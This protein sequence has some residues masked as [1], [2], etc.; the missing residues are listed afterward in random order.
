GVRLRDHPVGASQH[1]DGVG[2]AVVPPRQPGGGE[3]V[4]GGEAAQELVDRGGAH[5]ELLQPG[6]GAR[7][8]G[9]EV[10]G[11][12]LHGGAQVVEELFLDDGPADAAAPAELPVAVVEG[13]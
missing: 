6:G 12:A 1:A 11:A 13:G 9:E 10:V 8:Q 5:P 7:L 4:D 2:G 3:A